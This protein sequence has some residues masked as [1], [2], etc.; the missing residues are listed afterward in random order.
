MHQAFDTEL[1]LDT[2]NHNV[3]LRQTLRRALACDLHLPEE[4]VAV[5]ATMAALSAVSLKQQTLV[6]ESEP[7]AAEPD[8]L[9]AVSLETW[10]CVV[11]CAH[12]NATAS[13]WPPTSDL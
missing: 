6:V 13:T 7:V 11:A 1:S 2:G 12:A 10:C 8:D 9:E 4:H 3:A 5:A